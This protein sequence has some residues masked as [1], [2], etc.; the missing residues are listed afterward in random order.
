MMEVKREESRKSRPSEGLKF[1]RIPIL[2]AGRKFLGF[3]MKSLKSQKL[4]V[5]TF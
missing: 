1:V 3:V 4:K 5:A 2:T